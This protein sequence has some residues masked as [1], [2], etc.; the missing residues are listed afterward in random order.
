MIMAP[1]TCNCQSAKC[2][3][4]C[5]VHRPGLN[6]RWFVKALSEV[7]LGVR[8]W[9]LRR[10]PLRIKITAGF[11]LVSTVALAG[12]PNP[13][14]TLKVDAVELVAG[15][16]IEGKE[17]FSAQHGRYRYLL[18]TQANCDAFLKTP[19][20][21]EIQL[22]GACA[23]MGPLSG[24]G[25]TDLLGV[26]D[27]KI[28]IFASEQCRKRFM[29]APR[30]LLDRPDPPAAG[31]AAAIRRGRELLDLAVKEIGGEE[32]LS[33][34][35]SVHAEATSTTQQ[36]DKTYTNRKAWTIRFPSDFR[37]E[38]NWNESRWA[39]V[40]TKDDAYFATDEVWTMH[41]QQREALEKEFRHDP[42]VIL[43]SRSRSDFVAAAGGN[44]KVNDRAV[45]YVAVSFG[46][47]TSKLAID[48]ENGRIHSISFRGRGPTLA[49][50]D[51]ERNFSDFQTFEG[52][53]VPMSASA[54]FNGEPASGMTRRLDRVVV[55]PT[56]AAGV[57]ERPK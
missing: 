31:D 29:S 4:I 41:S 23:R 8:L 53:S 24:E 50:G 40:A 11:L 17:E 56:L 28:Y 34:L 3:S 39:A 21:F 7:D 5:V 2:W 36:G 26:H 43:Q 16:E 49:L 30:E 9:M 15:N 1:G 22:G 57:F 44:G 10:S 13:S 54:S 47:A 19:E 27:G 51:V 37:L 33:K 46:G 38:D 6:H 42:L 45:E 32:A 52:I 55:N 18:S 20:K 12:A 25:T 48:A 14:R 35:V